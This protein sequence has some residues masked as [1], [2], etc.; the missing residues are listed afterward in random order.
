[1]AAIEVILPKVDMDME[2][3]VIVGVEGRRGRPRQGGRHPV[4]D[5]NRQGDDGSRSAGQRRHPRPR[6]DHRRADRRSAPPVAWIDPDRR[7]APELTHRAGYPRSPRPSITPR[8][9]R[10]DSRYRV[11][12]S[13]LARAVRS[14]SR[15]RPGRG[16]GA[17][18]QARSLHVAARARRR[19]DGRRIQARP[20]RRRGRRIPL[21]HDRGHGQARRGILG[22][23]AEGRRAAAR[24]RRHDGVA[25]EGRSAACPIARRRSTASTPGSYDADRTYFGSKLITTGIA[26]NTAAKIASHIVG[27]S[28]EAG[29]QGPDRHAEPAVLRCGGDHA[30]HDDEPPGSR[31]ELLREA[32][33]RGRGRRARQRRRA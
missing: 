32:Q 20:S 22:G 26:V 28:R 3:G 16:A 24:R 25:E 33:G 9:N 18:G 15:G 27:R 11:A 12:T 23:R 13:I 31:L 6:A 4:R 2:S 30:R 29:I 10:H 17:Q 5:G 14:P 19:A 7:D 1:M 8:R 21:G